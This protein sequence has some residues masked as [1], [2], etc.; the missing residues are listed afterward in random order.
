MQ[1]Y[2]PQG[3]RAHPTDLDVLISQKAARDHRARRG[4]VALVQAAMPVVWRAKTACGWNVFSRCGKRGVQGSSKHFFGQSSLSCSLAHNLAV[5]LKGQLPFHKVSFFSDAKPT[6]IPA[7][8][9]SKSK[10][11]KVRCR[12]HH[13]QGWV[14]SCSNVCLREKLLHRPHFVKIVKGTTRMESTKSSSTAFPANKR[15]V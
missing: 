9:Q 4:C 13:A 14:R 10:L 15:T 3:W 7:S 1:A 2:D 6:V 11:T 8:G 12:E 5:S